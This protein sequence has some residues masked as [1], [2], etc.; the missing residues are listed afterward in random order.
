[1][2]LNT[3]TQHLHGQVFTHGGLP[4]R[5]RAHGV[6]PS[7]FQQRLVSFNVFTFIRAPGAIGAGSQGAI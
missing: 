4:R 6:N 7:G 2:G 3:D 5:E 1:M